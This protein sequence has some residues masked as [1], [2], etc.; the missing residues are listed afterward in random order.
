MQVNCSKLE[1]RWYNRTMQI[2]ASIWTILLSLALFI[3]AVAPVYAQDSPQVPLEAVDPGNVPI[4]N[5]SKARIKEV[6][7]DE[8]WQSGKYTFRSQTWLIEV[9]NGPEK[10]KEIELSQTDNLEANNRWFKEGDIVVLAKVSF[11]GNEE[12]QISDSYRVSALIWILIAFVALAVIFSRLKGITSLL[13]LAFSI[14][15]LLKF[16][17][18]AILEGS[19]AIIYTL[20]AS[21]MIAIVSIYLAH[22]LNKRTS[23]AILST[24]IT[25]VL[26]TF[27]SYL[28]VHFAMLFGLG[29]E[30]AFY[31]QSGIGNL[32]LKGLL[33]S[34]IIIG[35]LGVLDDITTAQTATVDEISKANPSLNFK[36]LYKR[37]ASV[38]KEH[39][40]SLVNTL[41]LAYAGASFPLFLLFIV[42]NK[43]PLWVTL[44]SEFVA[45]EVVRTIVGSS[46]LILAV[47]I[48]TVLAAYLLKKNW[49]TP[50]LIAW[51]K[52]ENN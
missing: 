35:T 22:G 2:K 28:F 38:G 47:P 1:S 21:F 9:L 19:N 12:Y 33:L 13:G 37:G 27:L 7:N 49:R 25:L 29:T 15:I 31:L 44:N 20:L 41:V 4:Q 23:V 8:T 24:L 52:R 5:F 34:G 30:E 6:K 3:S 32:N 14:F 17:A 18:P 42:N 46:A 39:I 51:T 50:K 26:A 43:Q 40:A 48:S 10:G 11:D 36:E 16:L 45:E